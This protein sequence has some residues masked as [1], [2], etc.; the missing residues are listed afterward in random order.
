M[1][2][3]RGDDRGDDFGVQKSKRSDDRPSGD[4]GSRPSSAMDGSCSCASD[5]RGG[6]VGGFS[7]PE[8]YLLLVDF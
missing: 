5:G 2:D 4:V 3:G 7:F 8:S 6:G 1:G